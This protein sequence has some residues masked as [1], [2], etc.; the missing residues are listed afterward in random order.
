M[1][2]LDPKAS[3]KIEGEQIDGAFTFDNVDYL[4]EGKWQKDPVERTD[5]QIFTG[6]LSSKLE[7]TL[8]LLLSINGFTESALNTKMGRQ[9]MF[10]MDG[11]DLLAILEE[12]IDLQD[13]LRRKRRHTSQTG[14]MFL[15]I[16]DILSN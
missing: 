15:S 12:R 16:H 3:F 4:F 10:L 2:D 13:L 14:N 7:N 6:K 5:I 11:N 8:G 1:F 9:Y